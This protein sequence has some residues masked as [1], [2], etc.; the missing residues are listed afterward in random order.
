MDGAG[1]QASSGFLEHPG[2][3]LLLPPRT[4]SARG[5]AWPYPP[6]RASLGGSPPPPPLASPA[7]APSASP[8]VGRAR[9]PAPIGTVPGA[10]ALCSAIPVLAGRGQ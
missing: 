9:A 10:W 6:S 8:Q 5:A 3:C 1:A 2:C 7:A 4:V